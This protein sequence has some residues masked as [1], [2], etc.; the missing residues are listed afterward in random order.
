MMTSALM[1]SEN[2]SRDNGENNN[3]NS[4]NNDSFAWYVRDNETDAGDFLFPEP[5]HPALSAD[6]DDWLSQESILDEIRKTF[7]VHQEPTTIVL[8]ILYSLT[9]VLGIIGNV[10]VIYIFAS[11]RHMRTVTNSFLVNLAVCDLLVV[12]LCIPFGVAME[13]YQNW[14]YGDAM[15]KIVNFSQGLA[16]SS[17]ILT[18][19]VISAERFYAIRRPLRARAFMSRTRIHRIVIAIWIVAAIAVLPNAFVRRE[20]LLDEILS[21]RICSCVEQ[22]DIMALKH[23][24]NFA[25]LFVLYLAPV[26]FICIG[27][28]QI[29]M[30]LWRRPA[31]LHA[32]I[33][34]AESANARSNLSGRRKVARMLFVMALLFALSWLPMHIFSIVL[35]LLPPE[36]LNEHGIVL[37]H[38]HSFFLWLGHTNSSINPLCYCVMST[39][40]KAAIRFELRRCCGCIKLF[41]MSRDHF[42][43]MSMSITG[44]STALGPA[45]GQARRSQLGYR[46]VINRKFSDPSKSSGS[47][48][49]DIV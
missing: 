17:S 29:G 19:T 49:V 36:T 34:A 16:V 9:F 8:I 6:L 22:W 32:G 42:R 10:L 39:S 24:Y 35:D 45:R 2:V 41:R 37:R 26:G 47:S 31:M 23:V 33:S 11:N 12:C 38:V 48:R 44:S 40:F 20:R 27:Y 3:N 4:N 7:F 21:L 14:V 28:L 15:C 13:V 5:Y 30:N 18:L 46:P 1:I 43:T 25:L